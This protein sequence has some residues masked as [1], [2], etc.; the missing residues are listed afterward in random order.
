[1]ERMSER[2]RNAFLGVILILLL[3]VVYRMIW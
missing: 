1:M 2:A 3:V